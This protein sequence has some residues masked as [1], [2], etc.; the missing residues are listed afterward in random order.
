[1][2]GIAASAGAAGFDPDCVEEIFS[3][4]GESCKITL[5]LPITMASV[6]SSEESTEEAKSSACQWS[7]IQSRP[8]KA[9]IFKLPTSGVTLRTCSLNLEFNKF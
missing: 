1:M 4:V 7:L 8:Q 5:M 2:P 3:A 9:G 6:F